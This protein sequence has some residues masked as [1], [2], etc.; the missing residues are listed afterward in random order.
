M[1]IIVALVLVLITNILAAVAGYRW[2]VSQER[3]KVVSRAAAVQAAAA[4]ARS[5]S[6]DDLVR[7]LRN[8]E[9]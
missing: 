5:D 2:R 6:P 8:N 7:R 3:G 9:F 4:S 1:D